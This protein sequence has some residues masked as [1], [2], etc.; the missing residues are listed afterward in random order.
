MAFDLS[1]I[2]PSRSEM[3][4][5]NTVEN[6]IQNIRGNTEII[7]VL[8]GEDA[9]PPLIPHPNLTVIRNYEPRGQ[10]GAQNQ[11]ARLSTARYVAK[12]DAHCSFDE[13]FDVKLMADMQDNWTIVPIMRNLWAFDWECQKCKARWYQG[14]TPTRCTSCDNTT[15][16]QRKI[17]W[18][19][20][21]NPQSTSYCF[22]STPHF[23][24]FKEYTKREEYQKALKET[25]LTETMSLQGSFF[26]CTREN[27]WKWNLCDEEAGSW[28]NQG[29]EVA[30]ATWLSGGKCVVSAKTWYAHMFRTQGGD[31][32]F[33]YE[34]SGRQVEKTKDYIKTKFWNKK[35][36]TQIYPVSWLIKKFMPISGWDEKSILQLENLEK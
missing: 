25:H 5:L 33:P 21:S 6:L 27:Y 34:Q 14:P 23:Q 28:G 16:F 4:L 18:V 22:D 8:D 2:I 20:K 32:S 13:G 31:F 11:A 3:F 12:C 9:N 17:M 30:A 7:V 10:R 15:D 36:P 29:L 35:H 19:G 24:Y 26:L 1:I